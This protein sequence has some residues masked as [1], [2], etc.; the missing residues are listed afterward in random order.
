[1]LNFE[2][3]EKTLVLKNITKSKIGGRIIDYST[4]GRFLVGLSAKVIEIALTNV[5]IRP[6]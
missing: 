6:T 3:A 1:M 5:A 2:M 4:K